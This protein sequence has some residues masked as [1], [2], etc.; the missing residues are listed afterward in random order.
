MLGL[1]LQKPTSWLNPETNV[2][3]YSKNSINL[4]ITIAFSTNN[5]ESNKKIHQSKLMTASG[6]QET[7][8]MV[9]LFG[10]VYFTIPNKLLFEAS[11]RTIWQ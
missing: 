9:Y 8:G 5:Q 1:S 11:E 6:Q 10:I 3:I 7:N 4:E 2:F